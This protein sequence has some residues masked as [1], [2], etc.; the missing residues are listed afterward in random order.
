MWQYLPFCAFCALVFY[1]QYTYTHFPISL[2]SLW[3]VDSLSLSCLSTRT[4]RSQFSL[5]SPPS[6]LFTFFIT[7][8]KHHQFSCKA[9]YYIV[10]IHIHLLVCVFVCLFYCGFSFLYAKVSHKNGTIKKWKTQMFTTKSSRHKQDIDLCLCKQCNAKD[11][12][13]KSQANTL[14]HW[15]S[16]I[17]REK[18]GEHTYSAYQIACW[19]RTSI[20]HTFINRYVYF[21]FNSVCLQPPVTITCATQSYFK[22]HTKRGERETES[23]GEKGKYHFNKLISAAY[24]RP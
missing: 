16:H 10:N 19:N 3:L 23:E 5:F 18:S 7:N 22:T 14:T 11:E 8:T 12:S 21:I 20:K 15:H 2:D 13:E 6:S 4:I 1:S 9:K 17:C 24:T